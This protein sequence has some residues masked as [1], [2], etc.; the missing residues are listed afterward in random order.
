MQRRLA[1]PEC[2]VPSVFEFDVG[3]SHPKTNLLDI[4]LV[5]V[6]SSLSTMLIVIVDKMEMRRVKTMAR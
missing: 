1:L 4:V 2:L 5:N 3:R 6:S